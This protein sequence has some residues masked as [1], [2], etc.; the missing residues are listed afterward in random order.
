MRRVALALAVVLV[1]VGWA[2]VDPRAGVR[3]WRDLG[4]DLGA[5]RERADALRAEVAEL[6]AEAESLQRDPLALEAAIRNDL[7]LARAGETIVRVARRGEA[8][9]AAR[10][11]ADP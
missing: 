6:E 2:F 4:K 11:A 5:A 9:A 8:P 7:G 3:V 1:A 10:A